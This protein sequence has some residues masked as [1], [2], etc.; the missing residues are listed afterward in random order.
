MEFND[1]PLAVFDTPMAVVKYLTEHEEYS[2]IIIAKQLYS[3][4]YVAT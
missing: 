2:T 1:L 4:S 3:Y